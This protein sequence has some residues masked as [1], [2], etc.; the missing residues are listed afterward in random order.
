VTLLLLGLLYFFIGAFTTASYALFMDMTDRR[1][2]ATQLSAYMSATNL[3]ESWSAFAVGAL[4][5][6][7]GYGAAFSVMAL[8][9]LVVLPVLWWLPSGR[10]AE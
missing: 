4:V 8:A 5:A 3:C 1:L 7:L 2:G 10:E 6:A 9:S